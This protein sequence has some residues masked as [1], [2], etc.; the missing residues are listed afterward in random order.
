MKKLGKHKIGRSCLYVNKLADVD[1]AVLET[2][3][4]RSVDHLNEKYG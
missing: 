2:L 1:M 3:I 4:R